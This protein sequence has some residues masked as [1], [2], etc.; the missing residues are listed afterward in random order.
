MVYGHVRVSTKDQNAARQISA[1]MNEG[2][3]EKNLFVDRK[4]G[5]DFQRKRY[6]SLLRKIKPGGVIFI[7]ELDCLGRNYTEIIENWRL[8]TVEKQTDIVVLDMPL[9]DTRKR[10]NDLTGRF[11][12]DLVLE[13][14]FLMSPKRN[15]GTFVS[16]RRKGLPPQRRETFISGTPVFYCRKIFR[17]LSA[18]GVS[19]S[20]PLSRLCNCWAR[21]EAISLNIYKEQ[22]L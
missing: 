15:V 20:F 19:T 10:G 6:Q 2:V 12:D 21:E 17:R 5:K 9:L 18:G 14:P 1:L 4:S 22:N 13:I 8:I 11:I 16:G 3:D 7:K